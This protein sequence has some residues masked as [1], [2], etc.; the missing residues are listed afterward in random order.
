MTSCHEIALQQSVGK[1]EKIKRNLKR[2]V[3]LQTILEMRTKS[4]MVLGMD[5]VCT[6]EI[7][8]MDTAFAFAQQPLFQ[9]EVTC[10]GIEAS[11]LFRPFVPKNVK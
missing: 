3:C 10:C 7:G 4:G 9:E 8:H 2:Q 5:I 6:V 11:L 1:R